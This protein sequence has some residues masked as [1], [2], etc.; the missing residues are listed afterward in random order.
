[1]RRKV[2]RLMTM[3]PARIRRRGAPVQRPIATPAVQPEVVSPPAKPKV[4]PPKAM[5]KKA[6]ETLRTAVKSESFAS[7]QLRVIRAAADHHYF[8]VKQVLRLLELVSFSD[9]K[10]KAIR[11]LYPRIIDPKNAFQLHGAFTF[12]SDKRKLRAILEN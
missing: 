2:S 4:K 10:L 12:E 11:A 1:M 9:K 5:A 7:N 8:S 3:T 6:F